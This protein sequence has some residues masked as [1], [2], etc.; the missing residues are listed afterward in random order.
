MLTGLYGFM[1]YIYGN[2]KIKYDYPLC[3]LNYCNYL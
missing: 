3:Y 2:L 1:I